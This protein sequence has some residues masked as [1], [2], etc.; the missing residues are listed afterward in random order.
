LWRRGCGE[1][2]SQRITDVEKRITNLELPQ[3]KV[4]Q[5]ALTG[6]RYP[7]ARPFIR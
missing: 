6:I 4:A 2:D 5:G 1:A 3:G 7:L